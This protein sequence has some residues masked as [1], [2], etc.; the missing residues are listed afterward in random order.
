MKFYCS[1]EKQRWPGTIS[2]FKDYGSH[3]EFRIESLSSITVL[4]GKTCLGYFAC[5]PD[6]AA[7]CHLIT[8]NN[9]KYNREELISVMNPI[10]GATVASAL[11]FLFE[12]SKI[13]GGLK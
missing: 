7:A 8:A 3:I 13:K 2:K 9:E 12:K 5:M 1:Y 4:Y 11:Y 6:F 10:D